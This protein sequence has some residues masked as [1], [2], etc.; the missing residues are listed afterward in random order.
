MILWS[1]LR[2]G[3]GRGGGWKVEDENEIL[4]MDGGRRRE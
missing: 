4:E 1:R 2:D 3:K